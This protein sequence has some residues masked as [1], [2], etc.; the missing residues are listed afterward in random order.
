[1]ASRVEIIERRRLR[2]GDREIDLAD[3]RARGRWGGHPGDRGV[4]RRG[5]RRERR[6]RHARRASTASPSTRPQGGALTVEAKPYAPH[7][8]VTRLR[9]DGDDAARRGDLPARAGRRRRPVRA[10]PRRRDGGRRARRARRRPLH[11]EPRP[12]ASS[13]CPATSA[14][15]G[16]CG[17]QI[18]RR[19]LRL[20]THLDGVANRGEATEYPRG[21]RRRPQPAALLHG[22]EQ[23]LDPLHRSPPRRRTP[24][25]PSR[26]TR[27]AKP[28][29]ARRVLG[30][31]AI[32]VHR[33]ALRLVAAR[34]GRA[35]PPD[36]RDVRILL[37]HAWGMG[38]TVRA[39]M[40]LA[41]SLVE[42]GR[43]VEV[44][45]VVRRNERPFFPFPD[46]VEVTAVDDQRKGGGTAGEAPEPARAPRRLRLPVVQ[47][48]DRRAARPPPARDARR[49]G[50]G[51][52][53]E[54]QPAARRAAAQG[55]ARGRPGAHELPR[56]PARARA[57]PRAPLPL[58]RRARR[59]DRG[60]PARLRG[61][62]RVARRSSGSPTRCR[63]CRASARGRR[64]R[65]PSRRAG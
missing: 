61:G 54:L 26:P 9:L 25:R 65:S 18:G 48:A 42:S 21:D 1:M 62:A 40:S 52:A 57:R 50:R 19:A 60:G 22:R 16:T 11:G 31:P 39:A 49:R 13:C 17:S 38:G 8:E 34:P 27:T 15:S 6:A 10:P 24:R 51:H 30:P 33:L 56:A 32:L 7:A 35:Q 44:V 14:T 36:G 3:A 46:G 4:R 47:P 12:R 29:L 37:L 20:G 45:S 58:A 43:S 2:V 41:A 59:A 64:A 28:R 53:A 55:H 23:R 63:R 5:G